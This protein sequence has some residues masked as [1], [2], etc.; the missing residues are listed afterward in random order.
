MII[1]LKELLIDVFVRLAK[2]PLL[3]GKL[4]IVD[5]KDFTNEMMIRLKQLLID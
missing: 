1:L 4:K 3:L 2:G 5:M